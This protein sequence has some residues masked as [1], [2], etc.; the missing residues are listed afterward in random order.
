MKKLILL[1]SFVAVALGA[2]AQIS[3]SGAG[4]YTQN[5]NS[6]GSGLPTGWNVY[7]GSSISG[8]GTLGNYSPLTVNAVYGLDTTCG[9]TTSGGFE[10]LPS[11][12]VATMQGANCT[13]QQAA[14]DRALG[15]R[16]VGKSNVDNPNLD[17][18][19]AFVFNIVNTIGGSGFQATFDLQSLD[20][21]SPRVTV[22]KVQYRIGT[23]GNFTDVTPTGTDM[24]TGGHSF[25][26]TPVT[27]NFGT[28]LDNNYNIFIRVVT[29]DLSTGTGNRASSA[30]DNFNLSWTGTLGIADVNG[31]GSLPLTVLGD[32]T[33]SDVKFAFSAL[34]AGEYTLALVDMT[35]RVVYNQKVNA[36][37]GEQTISVDGLSLT[38]GMYVARLSNGTNSGVA[39]VAV[40]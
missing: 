23:V 27:V 34:D 7:S 22:W 33:T 19:A 11:A 29:L 28:A 8:L 26:S 13:E 15:V 1:T 38:P 31:A 14:T 12:N 39:K 25:K 17:S 6:I 24:T 18:G 21:T 4:P 16:Q 20:T 32:A 9:N 2:S 36:K 35:G 10:N 5:F 37:A 30:I 3:L 40:K